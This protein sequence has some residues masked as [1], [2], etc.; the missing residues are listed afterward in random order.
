MWN[1]IKTIQGSNSVSKDM[2]FVK[3][4]VEI[5][6]EDVAHNFN[7]HFSNV[8]TTDELRDFDFLESNIPNF[9]KSLYL[10]PVSGPDVESLVDKLKS[11]NSSGYDNISY[12]LIKKCKHV[13]SGP[14][15][16]IINLSIEKGI[17]PCKFKLAIVHPLYKKGDPNDYNNYRAISLLCSFSKLLELHLKDQLSNFSQKNKLLS[18]G[19]HGF[20]ANKS[21]ESALCEFHHKIVKALDNIKIVVGLFIDFTRGFD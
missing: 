20:T 2:R 6:L 18:P 21:T 8:T 16:H 10:S 14:L 12:N 5:P 19:Q 13:I 17:F 4:G 7:L 1:I 15:A 11:S 9:N 3:D